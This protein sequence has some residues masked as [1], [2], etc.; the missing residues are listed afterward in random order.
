MDAGGSFLEG[1]MTGERTL[2]AV[3]IVS[4]KEGTHIFSSLL[5]NG[6]LPFA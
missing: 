3:K 2:V 5:H 6:Y 1:K 4:G